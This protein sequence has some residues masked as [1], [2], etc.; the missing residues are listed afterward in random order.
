MVQP[1]NEFLFQK[2]Y[3]NNNDCLGVVINKFLNGLYMTF[4]HVDDFIIK[5]YTIHER[6]LQSFYDGDLD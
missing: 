4:V 2:D 6:F 3:S 5:L 1:T